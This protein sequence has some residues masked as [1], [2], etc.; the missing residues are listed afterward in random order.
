M[1]RIAVVTSGGDASGMNAA[2]RAIVRT[3][4]DRGWEALGVRHGNAGLIAD[5][6]VPLGARSVSGIKALP[7]AQS[8]CCFQKWKLIRNG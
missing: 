2:I 6:F 4:I 5:S 8:A 1:K 7:E 3:A